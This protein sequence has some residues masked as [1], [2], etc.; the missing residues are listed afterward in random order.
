MIKHK[1][2][3]MQIPVCDVMMPSASMIAEKVRVDKSIMWSLF[4]VNILCL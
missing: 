4:M 1:I 3:A 2:P